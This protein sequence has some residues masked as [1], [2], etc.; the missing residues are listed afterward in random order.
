MKLAF[1]LKDL[2]KECQELSDRIEKMDL[3]V[4]LV[5]ENQGLSGFQPSK[6]TTRMARTLQRIRK[7]AADLHTAVSNG[8]EPHCHQHHEAKLRLLDRLDEIKLAGRRT[9]NRQQSLH[10][11]ELVFVGEAPA[12]LQL[13][14]EAA[15]HV[16]DESD[17]EF[18]APSSTPA[19]VTPVPLVRVTVVEPAV[20]AARQ[21]AKQ[22]KGICSFIQ[23]A[24]AIQQQPVFVLSSCC[25][26]DQSAKLERGSALCQSNTTM[27]PSVLLNNGKDISGEA[28]AISFKWTGRL[29][30]ALTVASTFLQ[31]FQTPWTAPKFSSEAIS[32]LIKPQKSL[33]WSDPYLS[34]SFKG[35]PTPLCSVSHIYHAVT[36]A[37]LE[38]GI[39]LLE[40][41]HATTLKEYLRLDEDPQGCKRQLCAI[42]WLEKEHG[43]MPGK[44][45]GAVA[46]CVSGIRC[47][48]LGRLPWD[49]IKIWESVCECVIEPLDIL[50]NA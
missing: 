16:F 12:P 20:I 31:L 43:N 14:H 8:W 24:K 37:F 39:M 10:I 45:E 26:L 7:H 23:Q 2:E 48:G 9:T 41:W 25:R 50:A 18:G 47:T 11:F 4:R 13:W 17:D 22:I 27:A 1:G 19:P 32:F 49:D 28:L 38:L 34:L 3:L 35:A 40:I 5:S 44:F 15:V 29:K 21:K 30:L 36:E 6:K 33:D 46:H 42:E